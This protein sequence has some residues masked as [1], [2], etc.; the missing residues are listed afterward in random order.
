MNNISIVAIDLAKSSFHLRAINHTGRA[1]VDKKL[2]RNELLL[3]VLEMPRS[4]TIAMEACGGAHYWGRTFA[5]HGFKVELIAPQFVKPFVK[6]Q[7]NDRADAEAIG[8]AASRSNMR[9]V[10][11]KSEEQQEIQSVHRVRQRLVRARTAL[12]N[13]TR[14]LIAEFGF[15][16]PVRQA[17]LREWLS[18]LDNHELPP[19]LRE[20]LHDLHEELLSLNERIQHYDKVLQRIAKTNPVCTRLTTIP[21]VGVNIATALVA[22]VG[23]PRQFKNG[24]AFA[25]WLGLVPRQFSTG[26]KTS[27]GGI[28]KRGDS[29]LR[30]LL[31]HGT[32]SV[33]G[34]AQRKKDSYNLWATKVREQ[35]GYNRAS[36]ALANRNARIAWALMVNPEARFSANHQQGS[37][38]H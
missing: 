12:M 7:K 8:E 24:R 11:V 3:K 21:G 35:R 30:T 4:A 15:V 20:T 26:G 19:L 2:S 17:A 9:T 1:V 38:L 25:A 6:S 27:L 14:G 31:I 34:V 16:L 36:V 37:P 13:E 33:I 18:D 28:S 23:N 32:R 5:S 22:A 10:S 29:Y